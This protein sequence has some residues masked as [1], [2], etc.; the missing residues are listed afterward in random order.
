M[1]VGTGKYQDQN[2][3]YPLDKKTLRTIALRSILAGGSFN[4]ET[5]QSVGWLWA[6]EPGLRKIHT[7]ETDLSLAMGHHLEYVNAGGFF[8]TLAMGITLAL[9]QQKADLETIRSVRTA[10]AAASKAAGDSLFYYLIFP[11]V[12]IMTAGPAAAGNVLP[13]LAAAAVL[14]V[15]AVFLRI[16]LMYYGYARGTRAAET[17]MRN[18]EALKNASRLAGLMMIGSLIVYSFDSD[19]LAMTLSASGETP[20]TLISHILP[21]L[22]P[23][24]LT[25]FCYYLLTK[26]NRSLAF[27]VIMIVIACL[28]AGVLGLFGNTVMPGS[29]I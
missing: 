8:S 19:I 7:D 4:G 26:K 11:L 22:I 14:I 25:W 24:L 16:S 6:I 1:V 15:F 17:L 18:A 21:G 3:A 10:S 28:A 13:V 27:C 29:W 12:L 23:L 9:E 20:G 2:E 5:A